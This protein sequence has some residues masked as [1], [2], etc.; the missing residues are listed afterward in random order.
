[1]RS[2]HKTIKVLRKTL[3]VNLGFTYTYTGASTYEHANKLKNTYLESGICATY[4]DYLDHFKKM[5]A[6]L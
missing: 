4:L 5:V 3:D 2:C 1:M 6:G